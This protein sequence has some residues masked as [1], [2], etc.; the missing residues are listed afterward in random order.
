MSD[1]ND[2]PSISANNFD[3]RVRE[4]LQTY[5]GRQ[6]DPLDR[7]LTLRD[8]IE[9]GI[10]KLPTGWTL[11]NGAGSLPLLPGDNSTTPST[12]DEPDLTPP[13]TPTGFTVTAGL[14]FFLV[15]HD[16]PSYTQGRGHLRTRLYGATWTTTL[17]TFADAVEIAQFTGRVY[18]HPTS[19][20]T[21]WRLWIKWESNDNVLSASPAG[22]TNGL[23]ANTGLVGTSDLTDALITAGKIANGAIDLGGSKIT[24]LLANANMAVITDPTKIADSLIGNTKLADLAITAGKIANG[25]IDLSGTKITGLLANANMAVITDPTKIADFLISSTKLADLA[26]TAGK[27]ASG[28]ITLTKF[29]SGIEPV[30]VATGALPTTK[31]TE[32]LAFGG[33]L[34]RWTGSAYTAAVDATDISGQVQNAQIAALAA[35]KITGQLTN[36]QIADVAAAK[37]TGQI[38]SAQISDGSVS[39]TKFASGLEPVTILASVPTVKSTTVIAVGGTLYRWNGSSYVSS[40][41]AADIS[42]LLADSQ[43]AALSASKLAGQITSTQITDGAIS[44]PK[45]AAGAVETAKIAAGAVTALQIAAGTI[46]GDRIAANTIA[47]SNIAADTITAAQIAAGAISASEL[48]AS[49]V[50]ADKLA[51]NSVTAVKIAAGAVET[52]KLAVGAVTADTIAANAITAAKIDAGAVTSAK[53]AA[54]TILASNIAAGT[55][56]GDRLA[57]NTITASQIA[58]DTITAAQIAAGAISASELAAGAV[59]AGKI[60]TGAIIANDG[61]IANG[62]ITNALIANAAVG[63]AQIVDAAITSAKIANLAVGTAAIQ[64][65]AIT[66]ALIANAAVG[67][68]QIVDA[69]ITNAKIGVAAVGA[70]AIQDLAVTNAKIANLAIDDAKVAGLSAAKITAGTIAADRLDSNV[71]TS[72]VLSVDWAKITNASVTSAQIADAAITSAKIASTIQSDNYASGSAGWRINRS[73]TAEFYN[74]TL[75]GKITAGATPATQVEVGANVAS[76]G[77]HGISLSAENYN[78]CFIRR[79]AD[80]AVFFNLNSGGTNAMSF[81]TVSGILQVRGDIE[82]TS[83]KVNTAMVSTLNINGSAVTV[84]VFGSSFVDTYTFG[85]GWTTVQT[86]NVPVSGLAGGEYIGLII[87]SVSSVY[88]ADNTATDVTLGIF[89]NGVLISELAASIDFF[90]FSH[91]GAGYALVTNGT[92]VIE[93]KYRVATPKTMTIVTYATALAGKR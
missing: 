17:P 72:K 70:A 10:V 64:T 55:I 78:N 38:T 1:R 71:I 27:I 81:N 4:T 8:L 48:A 11:R 49:A 76:A 33:K 77:H 9:N 83:L 28:A 85:T 91:A 79:E 75:R 86:T 80:G 35:S 84:P 20:G 32:T 58:S 15:E 44:A 14:S 23:A 43:I 68:A 82:A 5:L 13:P 69:A 36:A 56:T 47:G 12:E 42:G 21:K 92:N 7:G 46:T 30:T 60:A 24:G 26:V 65:G 62:A 93:F 74:I 88:P 50:T 40:V 54:G 3:Q 19:L 29:A 41:A 53:I 6:G 57:A 25:A 34:Y 18:A 63:S 45:I 16:N 67:S 2:L 37:L 66:T 87:N 51:A 59:T 39:G 52:A 73:G 89:V 31:S 90:G 22:G 61:V